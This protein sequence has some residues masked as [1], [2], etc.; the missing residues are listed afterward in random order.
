MVAIKEGLNLKIHLIVSVVVISLGFFF[1]IRRLEWVA[2][3][4]MIS[5]VISLELINSA[6]E[7]M[8]DLV[9]KERNSMAGKIKDIAAAAVLVV[10]VISVVVGILIFAPHLKPNT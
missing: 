4:I 5:L 3:L 2:L 1:K 8:V 10:A 6:M 7:N 9:T